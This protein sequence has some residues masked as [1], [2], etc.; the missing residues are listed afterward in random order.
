MGLMGIQLRIASKSALPQEFQ[1]KNGS[2]ETP[3]TT[4]T[5]P[6]SQEAPTPQAEATATQSEGGKQDGAA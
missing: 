6:V 5:E 4:S 2:V 3:V 1:L